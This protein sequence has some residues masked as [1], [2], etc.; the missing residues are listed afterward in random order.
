MVAQYN[1][2]VVVYNEDEDDGFGVALQGS[3]TS[4]G[5]ISARQNTFWKS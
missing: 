1:D 3:D 5:H 2:I 4:F